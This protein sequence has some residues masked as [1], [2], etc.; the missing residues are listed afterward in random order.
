[1]TDTFTCYW[2]HSMKEKRSNV[3]HQSG[4]GSVLLWDS[5][6]VLWKSRV[7]IL[8][9]LQDSFAYFNTL[10]K[11]LFKFGT[12]IHEINRQFWQ[13][14]GSVYLRTDTMQWF[15]G[16]LVSVFNW[17]VRSP[18]LKPIE[19]ILVVLACALYSNGREFDTVG[20]LKQVIEHEWPLLGNV[21]L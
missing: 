17:L 18:D 21:L 8:N 7:A 2:R 4:G 3:I 10:Q 15:S 1:M 6:F 5:F 13:D 20:T 16:H 19:N 14:D 12:L 11:Y 9:G